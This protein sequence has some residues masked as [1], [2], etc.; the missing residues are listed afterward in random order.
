MTTPTG[1]AATAP[2]TVS[3]AVLQLLTR[4]DVAG[5]AAAA[6]TEIEHRRSEQALPS[7]L[8]AERGDRA[9]LGGVMYV[10]DL[11]GCWH[12]DTSKGM[13][14]L[15]DEAM[16]DAVPV[17]LHGKLAINGYAVHV[18][19]QRAAACHADVEHVERLAAGEI[20]TGAPVAIASMSP[21][22][23]A[24]VYR[25]GESLLRGV[26]AEISRDRSASA[27]S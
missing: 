13:P 19:E 18:I 3:L 11:T 24:A 8:P 26:L 10:R 5:L 1:H 27:A 25:W 6:Q 7:W 14:H 15:T 16:V 21:R 17:V 20:S 2:A 9:W 22:Q 23:R 4:C 12:P